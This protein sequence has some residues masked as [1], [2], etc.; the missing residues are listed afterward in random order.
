[1]IKYKLGMLVSILILS[2]MI[3]HPLSAQVEEAPRENVTGEQTGDQGAGIMDTIFKALGD[4]AEESIE[5]GIEEFVGTYKGRIDEVKL[6]ERRGNAV[7]LE[8]NYKDVK[9]SD[10]VYVQGEVLKWGK[11]LEGFKSTLSTIRNKKGTVNLTIGWE[12]KGASEWGLDSEQVTSNQIRLSLVRETNPDRPFGALV[13]DFP[14][15]WTGSSEIEVPEEAATAEPS[16]S[17]DA[18]ELAEGETVDEDQT[19]STGT[20]AVIPSATLIP[21]GTVLKPA[22]TTLSKPS[23]AVRQPAT[24]TSAGQ[25]TATSPQSVSTSVKDPSRPSVKPKAAIPL[26]KPGLIY[27]M[28]QHFKLA[29]WR[30]AAGILPAPGSANDNRG[31]VRFLKEGKICPNTKAANLL[32]THPQWISN[33]WITGIYPRMKLGKNVKFKS[34]GALLNGASGSDGVVMEVFV[35]DKA[36]QTRIIRK[37]INCNGYKSLEADLSKWAGKTVSILLRVNAGKTSAQDWAVWVNP[38]LENR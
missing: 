37:R 30:S 23:A 6:L 32:Q 27:K 16:V 18:I 38:I 9:R 34:V 13:Y 17:D 14:K 35:L 12:Q 11:P 26:D 21:T 19:E 3:I 25:I 29:K 7:V 15:T 28:H 2:A 24:T 1:M 10:G 5:Q 8:V 20:T 33:G 22:Q 31:F 4:A 36:R